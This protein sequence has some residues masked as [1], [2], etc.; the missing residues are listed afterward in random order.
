VRRALALFL[1]VVPLGA[2]ASRPAEP[3]ASVFARGVAPSLAAKLPRLRELMLDGTRRKSPADRWWIPR[4]FTETPTL[5]NASYDRHSHMAALWALATWARVDGDAEATRG[6]MSRFDAANLRVERAF[7]ASTAAASPVRPYDQTWLLL[8]LVELERAADAETAA[9]ARRFRLE[10]EERLLA[11]AEESAVASTESTPTSRAARRRDPSPWLNGAYKSALWATLVLDLADRRSETTT[12]RL[13]A[14]RRTKWREAVTCL[15]ASAP[16]NVFRLTQGYD[17]FHSPAI[18]A[19]A[20][21]VA[22]ATSI[23]EDF[24]PPRYAL[25]VCEKSPD[26]ITLANCHRLGAEIT[27]T[28]PLAFD[29]GRGDFEARKVLNERLTELLERSDCWDGDFVTTSHWIP[30][31]VFFALWLAAGRP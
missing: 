15:G 21:R 8:L 29:A 17:F 4:G 26:K 27:K 9:E 25:P 1:T 19:L 20:A 6:I 13:D 16:E 22:P 31:F 7:V 23:P 18:A 30:Q 28:W 24:L 5:F 2:Q 10:C 12:S 3:A 11:F 14:L